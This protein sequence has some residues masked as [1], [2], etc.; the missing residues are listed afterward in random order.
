MLQICFPLSLRNVEGPTRARG[1]D[2]R[3]KTAR[4][5]WNRFSPDYAAQ[6]RRKRVQQFRSFSRW[7]WH[8][9]EVFV[10]VNGK[11]HCL[12]R[13]VDHEGEVSKTF[14]TKLRN[15]A[16]E[17]IFLK[18]LMKRQGKAEKMVTDHSASY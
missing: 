10:K 14:V 1:I 3:H 17:I 12:W 7:T 8:V 5:G 4:Y 11:R 6:I 9:D 13:A 2:V 16:A 15:K 18:K